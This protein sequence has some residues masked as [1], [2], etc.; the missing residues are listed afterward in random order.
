MSKKLL[1]IVVA[2][3]LAISITACTTQS[4]DTTTTEATVTG[5]NTSSSAEVTTSVEGSE[6]ST[7]SEVTTSEVRSSTVEETTAEVSSSISEETSTEV[8]SSSEETSIETE[9]ATTSMAAVNGEETPVLDSEFVSPAAIGDW[10]IGKR[11]STVDN[12]MHEV[13]FR[14]T[15]VNRNAE[16]VKSVVDAY[17]GTAESKLVNLS[18]EFLNYGL[19]EYEVFFPED[20]PASAEGIT[21]ANLNFKIADVS[22]EELEYEGQTF[23]GVADTIDV[24]EESETVR[25]PGSLYEGK[26]VFKIFDTVEEFSIV[27]R[28][29]S[30]G[31]NQVAVTRVQVPAGETS[32]E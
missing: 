29:F 14:V 15:G 16:D 20:F 22:G 7:S 30:D 3:A 13:Y 5:T 8:S 31:E 4:S 19:I 10:Q 24:T 23:A 32:A 2:G 21:M 28:Y 25:T 26:S 9:P 18:D 11:L 12:A 6:S 27:L 17:N 1:N